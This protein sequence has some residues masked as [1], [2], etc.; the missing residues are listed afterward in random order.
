MKNR[1]FVCL[2]LLS[3]TLTA[4]AAPTDPLESGFLNPPDSARPQ[5]WWHWMN[6]NVTKA[7]ITADL[8]A[9][10]RI[11]LGGAQIFS[12][13]V[14]IP[15]GLVKEVPY[16]S[17][18]WRKLEQHA[19]EECARLGLELSALTGDGWSGGGGPWIKP[20]NA[21]QRMTWSETP[22]NGPVKF[23]GNLP[24]PATKLDT[25]RDIA[26]LAI[27]V[28]PKLP[29]P[30]QTVQGNTIQL[31]YAEPVTVRAVT[32]TKE[33]KERLTHC[34]FQVSDDGKTF[35]SVGDFEIG[36][37][38]MSPTY[39]S[40]TFGFDAV[41]GRIFRVVL[42]Q[43]ATVKITL[44]AEARVSHWGLKA[45]F[46]QIREHGGGAPLFAETSHD[47]PAS[48]APG[49]ALDQV[50][51]LTT[52]LTGA[53][54][55]EWEVPPGQWTILRIGYT[56]TGHQCAPATEA[57]RGL[58]CDKLSRRGIEAQFDGM[59]GKLL[60]QFGALA[61]KTFTQ[62]IIDSWEVR[63]QNWT[64][65]FQDEFKKRRGYDLMPWL[66][67][68]A[69][70]H[71]VGNRD[72]SER[73]LWDLRRTIAD[74]IAENFWGHLTRLCHEHGIIFQG[75]PGGRQQYLYDPIVFQK[76]ADIPMGEFWVGGG[77]RVDC[78]TAA[79]AAHLYGKSVVAAESF[80]K[81]KEGN[82]MDD[83]YSMKTLGD[84]A[85]CLGINRFVFHRYAHQPWL[86]LKPGMTMGPHG[87]NLDR[88]T[89]W[90]D[91]GAAW[92]S[93]LTR[94]QH[95]LQQGQFV[96]DVVHLIGEGAPCYLGWREQMHPALPAGFDYDGCDAEA[97]LRLLSV[98]DGRL[99]TPSGMNY[100][101]LLL[102]DSEVMTPAVAT[103]IRELIRDGALVF[104]P[105]P[106]RSPSLND[107]P[108][109]DQQVQAIARE[110]W[111][112]CDGKTVKTHS[113]GKGRVGWGQEFNE[114]AGE[115]GLQPDFECQL[116]SG[117][118]ELLY[119]H[120]RTAESDLYFVSNQADAGFD[121]LCTFRVTGKQP[122]LWDAASG[123]IR[124]AARY[125]EKGG[126]TTVQIPFDPRGSWFV[127]F[128][129]PASPLAI[130]PEMPAQA[131]HAPIQPLLAKNTGVTNNFTILFR[132]KL[133]MDIALPKVIDA[134]IGSAKDQNYAVKPEQGEKMFGEGHANMGVSV[135][136]NGVV[137]WEHGARYQ[138]S[139]IVAGENL[140]TAAHIAVVYCHRQPTLY[141]NGKAAGTA[142]ASAFT[143]HPGHPPT[144]KG[145]LVDL[146]LVPRALTAEEVSA[147]AARLAIPKSPT[148]LWIENGTRVEE[149]ETEALPLD[150]DWQVAFQAERGA[151]ASA[152]LDKL[153]DLS[154]HSVEGIRY[155]SG[156][157]TYRKTIQLSGSQLRQGKLYLDLGVVHNLAEVSING[158]NLGVLWKR[159]FLADIT[160]ALKDGENEIE[161]R[162]TNLW[163]NRLI[164][165]AKKMSAAGVVYNRRDAIAKWPDWVPKDAPPPDAPVTFATW[166]QWQGNEPLQ[167]SGLLGPVTLQ[168]VAIIP[169]N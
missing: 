59:M 154:R 52:H 118:G 47:A 146:E 155:F 129:K 109:C 135:G 42:A 75:E 165:D 161:V 62:A 116:A 78:R 113:F 51:N 21:M 74:L 112:D 11:G 3:L 131:S 86:N 55:L 67:V 44:D 23:A 72:Q 169:S 24:Q 93:Y 65:G 139:R 91:Q 97:V 160:D 30:Y 83:P 4:S 120:R 18:D 133:T 22:V 40:V 166:R 28:P 69:G 81:L 99:V 111:G 134:G 108:N 156:T 98:K 35:R 76:Q 50:V 41:R 92:I 73:F 60:K 110:V 70:G 132:V 106:A 126:R 38:G 12:V 145:E 138:P 117:Q 80:T 119:I 136:Q 125:A 140:T 53:G 5:T 104:G 6:G 37:A 130:K 20:D 17:D 64:A 31:T 151:P 26:V 144:F 84:F 2:F 85:F 90:W 147:R 16:F 153:M 159:P 77:P 39:P 63:E 107:Y 27:P 96:A 148:R 124:D 79:S 43:A 33:E 94:S 121:A 158:R 167:P 14:G 149:K 150:A 7:G 46:D 32:L 168:T 89:T 71:V 49:I 34:E 82:W 9:M 88:T 100:R 162:V 141:I 57:G 127:V 101:L 29:V 152:H 61:G 68:M 142:A 10:K 95:L 128:R 102:P 1:L 66:P 13:P 19:A 45:G 105:R 56:P 115:I 87:I 163:V 137:L 36:Q 123:K 8:E 114:L 54:R 164:G 25:Y 48:A 157:A 122:E 103:R 143:V 58:E 15:T